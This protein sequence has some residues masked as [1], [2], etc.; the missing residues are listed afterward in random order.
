MFHF[1]VGSYSI[2]YLEHQVMIDIQSYYM[3]LQCYHLAYMNRSQPDTTT[4]RVNKNRQYHSQHVYTD[5]LG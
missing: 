3:Y 1:L 5:Y 4:S 2:K